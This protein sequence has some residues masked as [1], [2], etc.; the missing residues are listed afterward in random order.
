MRIRL[1]SGRYLHYLRPRIE[2]RKTP[3][4]EMRLTVTYEG[5][6]QNTRQWV[7][8]STHPGKWME[9]IIQ[10]IARDVLAAGLI[11]ADRIGFDIIGHVHD[12]IIALTPDDSPLTV[13]DLENA[14]CV[15]LPW[16]P[17]MPLKAEGWQGPYYKKD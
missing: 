3:W 2:P 7:R 14:M 12:E 8:L 15:P 11:E 9:N 4:G 17:D 1:P 10:A 13:A 5:L 6:D 16:A